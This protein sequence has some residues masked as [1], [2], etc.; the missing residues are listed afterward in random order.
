[1]IINSSYCDDDDE[2]DAFSRLPGCT[3]HLL[4]ELLQSCPV[5]CDSMDCSLLAS[6]VH[7]ISRQEYWSG[8]SR[9]EYWSGLPCLPPGDLPHPGIKPESCGSCIGGRFF[10]TELLGKPRAKHSINGKDN[11]DA[12]GRRKWQPTPVFLPGK[13]HGQ[14]SLVG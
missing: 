12:N 4:A 1:M 14:R 6:S 11:K 5:L 10:T 3:K 8:I 13:V 7:W 9:Q 2:N